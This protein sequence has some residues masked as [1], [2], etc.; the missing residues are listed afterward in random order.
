MILVLA[1]TRDG[2]ELA[3]R[4]S[5]KGYNILA[6]A[7]SKYGG[8]LLETSGADEVVAKGLTHQELEEIVQKKEINLIIDATHPFAQQISLQAIAIAQELSLPYL[9]FERKSA[10]LPQNSLL[11]RVGTIE[12]AAEMAM[13]LGKKIFLTTGSKNLTTFLAKQKDGYPRIIA[14]VLPDPGVMEKCFSLGL[15]PS[16]IIAIQGPFSKELNKTLFQEY[17]ADVIVTKESGQ[18]GGTDSKIE[19]ALELSIP[20]VVV[21]RPKLEYPLIAESFEEVDSFLNKIL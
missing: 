13:S 3:R 15:S 14:R 18:T 16:D 9:R 4:L 20:L 1:G 5:Q 2:R 11:Y 8:D 6:T 19:A 7:V 17:Q 12:E 21:E 10:R